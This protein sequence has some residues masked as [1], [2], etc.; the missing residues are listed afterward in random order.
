MT[1]DRDTV[2]P[3]GHHTELAVA[4][5][6]HVLDPDQQ[7]EFLSH[8]EL[9]GCEECAAVIAETSEALGEVAH[10][11]PQQD[12]PPRARERLLAAVAEDQ[13]ADATRG[14]RV[15]DAPASV[16]RLEDRGPRAERTA[17]G[18]GAGPDGDEDGRRGATVRPLRRPLVRQGLTLVAAAAAVVVIGGLVVANQSLREQRDLQATQ[19]QQYDRVVDV[20]RDAGAP[21]AVSAP[22]AQPDGALV[23]LVVDQGRGPEVLVTGLGPNGPDE[24]YVLWALAGRTPIAMGTFDVPGGDATVRDVPS[25]GSAGP[26]K[27]Y[28]VSLE[29]G[30]TAPAAPTRVVASGQVG[31]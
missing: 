31:R 7:A 6:L 26:V 13:S 11:V 20:M 10:A 30:R 15:R 24:T 2:T 27:G 23:G 3:S 17:A 12:P 18:A 25:T 8:L 4:W 19:A 9:E 28:A 5:V 1:D 29:L 21:G 22:L 16:H 14:D